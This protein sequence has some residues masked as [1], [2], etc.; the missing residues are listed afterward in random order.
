MKPLST[1][2]PACLGYTSAPLLFNAACG[3]TPMPLLR[4][5]LW[6]YLTVC[7]LLSVKDR[8]GF[9]TGACTDRSVVLLREV[10]YSGDA[11]SWPA[12]DAVSHWCYLHGFHESLTKS[13]SILREKVTASGG[14]FTTRVTCTSTAQTVCTQ[15]PPEPSHVLAVGQTGNAW[16]LPRA[17]RADACVSFLS[18][19]NPLAA[20]VGCWLGVAVLAW[21]GTGGAGLCSLVRSA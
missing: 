8:V 20:W 17:R 13:V 12:H 4:C 18:S 5:L 1:R 2:T 6:V 3:S 14:C 9:H 19:S 16:E 15:I 21:L 11:S 7:L 10:R